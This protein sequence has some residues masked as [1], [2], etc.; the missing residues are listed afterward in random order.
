MR[1]SSEAS[2]VKKF[3][4]LL[5]FSLIMA[6]S[7]FGFE[8]IVILPFG[9]ESEKQEVYWLG[10][11]FA[12]SL[13]EELQ[14]KDVAVIPR[15]QRK[16]VYDDLRLPYVG[17]LSRATMLKIGEKLGA[18]YMVFGSYTLKDNDLSVEAKVIRLS[19]MKLSDP[20]TATGSLDHLY[21]IQ[22][23]IRDGLI[24]FFAGEKLAPEETKLSEQSVPLHAYESYIKGLLENSDNERI[25]FF[26]RAIQANPGYAQAIYRLGLTLSRVQRYKDSTD[27][28]NKGTFTDPLLS[29]VRFLIGLNAYQSQSYDEALQI[30]QDLSKTQPSAEVYNNLGIALMQKKNFQDSGWYASKAVELDPLNPDYRFNLAA[31]YILRSF[32]PNAIQEYRELI[33]KRNDDYQAFYLLGKLLEKN[34][35]GDKQKDVASKIVMQFFNDTL[36]TDQKG[37]FPEMYTTVLQLLR[38]VPEFLSSEE[39][40]YLSAAQEKKLDDFASYVRTYQASA[41]KY[42]D[43]DDSANA[44]LE[45]RKGAGLNPLDWYLH[46][47]SGLAQ[48]RQKN[49]D[50]AEPELQF[51]LWCQE[52]VESHLLLAELYREQEKYADAKLQIQQSLA[53]D[54]DN[55]KALE[56]WNKIWDKK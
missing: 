41:R 12:E 25:Q 49:A 18:D 40:E 42:I 30:W 20:V 56:I 43:D 3:V 55:K 9:N 15:K 23:R 52:N 5:S 6:R 53:L 29:K 37:K 36:P 44:L 34:A 7:S 31:S 4:L 22:R 35:A 8:S 28:L 48:S 46:Y 51:S 19:S 54:P 27:C 14:L 17:D 39:R 16:T 26:Q 11:G 13:G 32:A 2:L 24:Q 10:E 50:A 33:K 21:E 38:S 1:L 47:L 45:I